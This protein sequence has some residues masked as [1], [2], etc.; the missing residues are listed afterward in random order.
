MGYRVKSLEARNGH[1][2]RQA[3]AERQAEAEVEEDQPQ[4]MDLRTQILAWEVGAAG[5]VGLQQ[6]NQAWKVSVAQSR[7]QEME[8]VVEGEAVGDLIR[9]L[10]LMAPILVPLAAG[11]GEV[12]LTRSQVSVVTCLEPSEEAVEVEDQ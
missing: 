1:V 12:V 5:V 3:W 7:D 4:V 11:V 10:A 8:T 2:E 6:R 9:N